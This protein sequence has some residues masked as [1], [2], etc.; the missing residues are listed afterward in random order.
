M[1]PDYNQ[2]EQ[3]ARRSASIWIVGVLILGSVSAFA[4]LKSD[5][6]NQHNLPDTA[7]LNPAMLLDAKQ[8]VADGQAKVALDT[9]L[10]RAEAFLEAPIVSVMD[11]E[12][13]PP[14]GDFHDYITLAPYF[15]PNP[16]TPDGLPYIK[17]DGELHEPNRSGTDFYTRAQMEEG[18]ITLG[19]AFYL[20]DDQKYANGAATRLRTWFLDPE[21][22]MNPNLNF[23]QGVP[24]IMDGSLW[25]IIETWRWTAIVDIINLIGSSDEWTE[26]DAR[27]MQQWF[28]DYQV[29]LRTSEL[30]FDESLMWNNHG[31]F[32]DS[33]VA[34]LALHA[35]K[36]EI[37]RDILLEA[38]N[39]RI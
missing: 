20:T 5:D 18:V 27:G 30:G 12:I 2:S 31:S 34:Y 38:R 6:S 22:R 1:P 16:D 15:W 32:Y 37:A 3:R 14:S 13:E 19:V 39:R 36:P 11:K 21:T 8:R 35:G 33:Q 17:R 10:A 7:I 28:D 23:A 29:W 25:G 24:G 26:D 9:L 4:L